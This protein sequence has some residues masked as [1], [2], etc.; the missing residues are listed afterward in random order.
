MEL[1]LRVRPRGVSAPPGRLSVRSIFPSARDSNKAQWARV[2]N[3]PLS[4]PPRHFVFGP[5]EITTDPDRFEFSALGGSAQRLRVDAQP[6][7]QFLGA[8]V[9][10]DHAAVASTI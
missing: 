2:I 4:Q 3:L 6:L 9:L 8:E 7:G 5:A 1:Y 10:R